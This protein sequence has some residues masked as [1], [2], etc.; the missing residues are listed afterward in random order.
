MLTKFSVSPFQT[1]MALVTSVL[2]I[3]WSYSEFFEKKKLQ[4]DRLLE[5]K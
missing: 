3:P 5:K 2:N 1:N 4:H